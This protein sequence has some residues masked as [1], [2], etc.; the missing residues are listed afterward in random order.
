MRLDLS[1]STAVKQVLTTQST[2]GYGDAALI[3]G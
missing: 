1:Y 2:V 3:S